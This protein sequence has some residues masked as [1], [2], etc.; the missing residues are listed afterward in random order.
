MSLIKKLLED[1]ELIHQ[2]KVLATEFGSQ[3][4]YVSLKPS[5]VSLVPR[6]LTPLLTSTDIKL[7]VVPISIWRQNTRIHKIKQINLFY[8]KTTAI[9]SLPLYPLVLVARSS[10]LFCKIR[11]V[12]SQTTIQGL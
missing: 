12:F 9:L 6:N 1:S 7:D 4:P 10:F 8:K 3:H 5:S 2:Y 11:K